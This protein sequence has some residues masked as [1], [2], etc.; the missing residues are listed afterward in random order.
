M[1]LKTWAVKWASSTMEKLVDTLVQYK[2]TQVLPGRGIDEQNLWL[3][4][5]S[6]S[7]GFLLHFCCSSNLQLY[8]SNPGPLLLFLVSTDISMKYYPKYLSDF[9]CELLVASCV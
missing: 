8:F 5:S 2:G 9:C 3:L 6:S 7:S 4:P 1:D